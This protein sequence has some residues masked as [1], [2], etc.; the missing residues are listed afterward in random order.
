MR[1][2]NLFNSPATMT[3]PEVRQFIAENSQQEFQL[4]D[5]REPKEYQEHHIP[6]ALLIPLGELPKRYTELDP[7]KTTI[8]Y[9][10]SG[11]RSRSA[12]QLLGEKNFTH[13]FNMSGGIMAWEGE[14]VRGGI[15]EGIG[16]FLQKDY[17]SYYELSC[18]LEAGLRFFY[19]EMSNRYRAEGKS[20][21]AELLNKMAQFE[22]SHIAR[23]QT[24]HN[25]EQPEKP[26]V[27]DEMIAEGG[28]NTEKLIKAFSP[29]LETSQSVLQLAMS[30]EAQAYDLYFRLQNR[31]KDS[32][33]IEFFT[34]MAEE[35]QQ[36]LKILSRELNKLLEQ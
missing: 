34:K 25:K 28:Y 21:V 31:T 6:G 35:E 7:A 4:V 3:T 11:V 17:N 20:E 29:N 33:K 1:W 13:I 16:Y 15:D 36:H 10:R 2:R 30:F 14:R 22:D 26:L 8:V 27:I 19:Q 12:C 23:L 9:C 32:A 18:A 5:V 24:M